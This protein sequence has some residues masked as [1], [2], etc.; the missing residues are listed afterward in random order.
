MA[1][2][3]RGLLDAVAA[4]NPTLDLGLGLLA[5]SSEQ[6]FGSALASGAQFAQVRGDSRLENEAQRER[7]LARRRQQEG[8]QQLQGLLAD[9]QPIDPTNPELIGLLGQISPEGVTRGLLGQMFPPAAGMDDILKTFQIQAIQGELAEKAEEKAEERDIQVGTLNQ[10]TRNLAEI[11]GLNEG[12]AGTPLE[13]GAGFGEARKSAVRS[14]GGALRLFGFDDRGA[15]QLIADSDRF[16]KLASDLII[17][18][19]ETM[20]GVTTN[21]RQELLQRATV[22]T[23]AAPGANRLIIADLMEEALAAADREGI[24]IQDRQAREA[25]IG[26]LRAPTAPTLEGGGIPDN[27][28]LGRAIQSGRGA[29]FDSTALGAARGAVESGRNI[30]DRGIEAGADVAE[31]AADLTGRAIAQ[32]ESV[33]D[34]TIDQLSRIN[35]EGMSQDAKEMARRITEQVARV[36]RMSLEQLRQ[37]DHSRM[38][39]AV[40]QAA[41][42][43]AE[44]LLG[45]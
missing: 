30:V 17:K 45:R 35:P 12:L 34:M 21:R 20:P 31:G 23:D 29:E 36:G 27:A 8:V 4:G 22:S 9:G 19:I 7:I 15:A 39:A 26:Q 13:P 37:I 28:V 10:M 1:N 5:A 16:D 2:G 42:Q 38:S 25:L 41:E 3:F 14:G 24:T 11:A 43:R 44:Q 6:P 40:L 32:I 18:Q 33:R